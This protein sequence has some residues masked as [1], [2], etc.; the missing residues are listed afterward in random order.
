MSIGGSV[1]ASSLAEHGLID[2]YR[3]YI[4]PIILGR[5]KPMFQLHDRINLSL[6]GVQKFSSGVVLLHYRRGDSRQ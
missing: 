2:E 5:G 3:L 6:V 4:V 1:L